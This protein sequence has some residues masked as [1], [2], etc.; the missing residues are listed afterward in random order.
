M[1]LV[2]NRHDSD[3]LAS[4]LYSMDTVEKIEEYFESLEEYVFSSL[5]A[6][7]A[8][9]PS[10]HEAVNRLWLDISRYGPGMP[11]FPEMHLP[12]LGDFQ[13]PPPPPP[14]PPPPHLTWISK[15]AHW[16]ARH[17]WMTSTVVVGVV[18]VG[19]LAGY[20]AADT[21]KQRRYRVKAQTSE[22]QQ[23]VGK[24]SRCLSFAFHRSSIQSYSEETRRWLFR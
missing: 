10:V 15:S 6:A 1:A 14:P 11:T 5:S 7:T 18:G 8:E 24:S 13:V 4:A 3:I 16:F 20:R 23:V 19:L 2:G 21:R 22:R 17:P 9:F 12:H